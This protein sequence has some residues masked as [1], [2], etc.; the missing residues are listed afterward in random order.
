LS[1]I[2]A[3]N[4]LK[5]RKKKKGEPWV[6][7]LLTKTSP[8]QREREEENGSHMGTNFNYHPYPPPKKKKK[9]KKI[10]FVKS[11]PET[12]NLIS[13]KLHLLENP[14]ERSIMRIL[15]LSLLVFFT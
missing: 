2:D 1:Y 7:L 8:T 11:I 10:Q 15:K 9:K 14:C 13:H 4:A 6:Q 5:K 12:T 3:G